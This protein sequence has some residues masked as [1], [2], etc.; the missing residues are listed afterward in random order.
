MR[1][2]L[3]R[4]RGIT[5]TAATAP[6]AE[7]LEA[8]L[9]VVLHPLELRLELLVAELQ[10]L[11]GAGELAQRA[12]QP[13][14]PHRQGAGIGIVGLRLLAAARLDLL[15]LLLAAARFAAAEQVVEEIALLRM[16]GARQ[17]QHGKCGQ[18]R[19]AD[20]AEKLRRH[21]TLRT[22]AVIRHNTGSIRRA[23]SKL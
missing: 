14:E 4:R 23:A 10:L 13:V 1:T 12:F 6:R 15:L 20:T 19:S 3:R 5:A 2:L 21:V 8:V 16:R 22:G 11:D 9:V 18:R 17:Q 7:L